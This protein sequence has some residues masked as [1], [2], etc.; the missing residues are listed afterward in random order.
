[1][2]N[3]KKTLAVVLAFAMILSFGAISTF[4]YSDVEASTTTGEAVSILSNLGILSGFEDGTFRPDETVTRAQMASIIVRTLGY[5]SQAVSSAGS[6]VFSDVA[7]DHWA[8]GYINVA[9]AQGIISGYGNGMFGPEDKVTYEQAVKMIVSALGYDLVAVQKGGYPTGYLAVASAEG[10][11]KN[12]NGRVGDP[13]KRSSIAILVYNSLEVRLLDQSSWTTD[14]SDEYKKTDKTIL[15]DYLDVEKWEGV[16]TTVPYLDYASTGYDEKNQDIT[17]DG[18]KSFYLNGVSTKD[19]DSVTANAS[20][21]DAGS[22]LGKKVVAYVGA[23]E[24]EKTDEIMV[25]AIAEKKSSNSSVTVSAT[26]LADNDYSGY[27]TAGQISYKNGS[28]TVDASLASDVKFYVNFAAP[29][30]ASGLGATASTADVVAAVATAGGSVELISNDADSDIEVVV[31]TAYDEEAVIEDVTTEDGVISFET[32]TGSLDDIDLE[33]EDELVVVYKDGELAKAED[34]AAN[35]TVSIVNAGSDFTILYASSATVTGSVSSYDDDY[36]T[37][38]GVEYEMSPASGLAPSNIKDEEGTFFLNVDGQIAHNETE[39]VAG[40]N[41]GLVIAV[42]N[43]TGIT[44]GYEAQVVLADGT[45]ATYPITKKAKVVSA[46]NA[47]QADGEAAVYN[48]LKALMTST[49]NSAP[50][51]YAKA[52]DL[53]D[54]T[55]NV[56]VKNGSISKLKE[57]GNGTSV[58]N[59]KYD[60][61]SM[62]YGALEFDDAT[63]VF[64]VDVPTSANAKVSYDDITV[65]AVKDFFV[66]G[67]E[68]YDVIGLDYDKVHGVVLGFDLAVSVPADSD[69]VIITSKKTVNYDDDTATLITGIQGG[70]EVTYTI[71]DDEGDYRSAGSVNPENLTKGDVIL[72]A[73]ANADGIVSDFKPLFVAASKTKTGITTNTVASNVTADDE[74]Y[75]FSKVDFGWNSVANEYESK[76]TSTKFW[77]ED[78]L[79]GITDDKGIIMKTAANYTLVDLSESTSNPVISKKAAGTSLFGSASKYE[80]FVFVRVY[81][82]KLAEVVVYRYNGD[83]K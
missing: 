71:Y 5:D 61:E 19:Y 74:Y 34:L 27:N 4:A 1:M 78:D 45:V 82:D 70:K 75:G 81:D 65:G 63:V 3:L 32:Y 59:K 76:P 42:D 77:V 24:D 28:K 43:S 22:L 8:S 14:G 48:Y 31:I 67:D 50:T 6:T 53:E 62:T 41:Y 7:A 38:G 79:T 18:F 39:T 83:N 56:T 58:N 17:I 37:I 69:A 29:A 72:V 15:S 25:Y 49:D 33:D 57:I 11:T 21:V 20:L 13:A 36:A 51:Y 68:D 40:G 52:A 54:L 73:P 66:D 12:A 35:D 60:A 46:N 55:F 10:I 16:V 26:K 47:T 2:K 23:E 30:A 44:S 80:S 64:A 9:Q